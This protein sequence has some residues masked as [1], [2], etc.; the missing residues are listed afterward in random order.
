MESLTNQSVTWTDESRSTQAQWNSVARRIQEY[1]GLDDNWD[2][3]GAEA[4]NE[5]LFPTVLDLI[6]TC[7]QS[8]M[9]A[10]DTVVPVST[11]GFLFEW[12]NPGMYVE[13]EVVEA[14]AAEFMVQ[15]EDKE[16][17]FYELRFPTKQVNDP[18]GSSSYAA[19]PSM[20]GWLDVSS[21]ST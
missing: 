21:A 10:P 16:P 4:P 20:R 14:G 19:P 12:H 15:E 13:A 6:S 11:G 1:L 9:N 7:I 2:G 18:F 3:M 5:D 8:G 17:D